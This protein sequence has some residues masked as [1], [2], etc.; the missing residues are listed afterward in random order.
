MSSFCIK[1]DVIIKLIINF[2]AKDK[3]IFVSFVIKE[4]DAKTIINV[5]EIINPGIMD[6]N[7]EQHVERNN[8]W[9]MYGQFHKDIN[10]LINIPHATDSIVLNTVNVINNNTTLVIVFRIPTRNNQFVAFNA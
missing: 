3:K 8:T 10:V 6:F 7:I 4:T 1:Y 5:I 2:K 9:Y